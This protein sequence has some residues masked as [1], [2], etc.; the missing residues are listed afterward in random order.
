MNYK[1]TVYNHYR[2]AFKGVSDAGSQRFGADKIRPLLAPWVT[3]VDKH[4]KCADLGC[5]AGELLLALKNLGFRR[6]TGC[7][8]SSEQI[9]VSKRNFPD[10]THGNLFDFL[11]GCGDGSLGLVTIFDVIEH[12]G[13]QSTF[14]LFTLVHQKLEPGG[15]LIAHLPNGLSP[16]VGSVLWG[17]MTHA[18]CLTPESART[19][20]QL[21]GFDAYEAVEHLGASRGIRG[22][23]RSLAWNCLKLVMRGANL[24]ETGQTGGSIWTRNFA[25]KAAKPRSS[26]SKGEK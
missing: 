9:E 4:S 12:L 11:S 2:S 10:V 18:W 8:L 14:D 23:L 24:I 22:L 7:D 17:D 19:L 25:F 16:F 5:G 1:E 6:L 26:N 13:P 21:H 20:C 3:Q 15:L